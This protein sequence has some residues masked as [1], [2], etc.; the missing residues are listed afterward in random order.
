MKSQSA[1]PK[2][3][4][5]PVTIRVSGKLFQG[6]LSYL[7]QLVESAADCQLWPVLSLSG[8]EELD[9]AAILYL[10]RGENHSFSVVSCPA[11]VRGRMDRERE[12]AAA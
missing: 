6:H 11:F 4:D 8:L 5:P 9:R 3:P 7:H 2:R 1:S 10:I 12:Q